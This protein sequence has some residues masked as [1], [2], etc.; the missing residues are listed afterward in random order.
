MDDDVDI[1]NWDYSSSDDPDICDLILTTDGGDLQAVRAIRKKY[2][3][4]PSTI[5][6]HM[7]NS[8]VDQLI[9]RLQ[10]TVG[11]SP[12]AAIATLNILEN[13]VRTCG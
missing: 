9:Y 6:F 13:C 11:V 5:I 8:C 10:K 7:V 12:K 3:H 4:L 1:E 2:E